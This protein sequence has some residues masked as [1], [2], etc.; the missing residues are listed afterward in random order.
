MKYLKVSE[1]CARYSVS[2]QTVYRMLKEMESL[3]RYPDELIVPMDTSYRV[4]EAAVH[5]YMVNRKALKHGIPVEEFDIRK[6]GAMVRRI[7]A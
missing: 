4:H 6:A 1:W 3:H 5:D 7:T 2:R